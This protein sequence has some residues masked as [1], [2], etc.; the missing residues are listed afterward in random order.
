MFQIYACLTVDQS[1]DPDHGLGIK[2][3]PLEL[4]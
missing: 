3:H 1:I 2:Q 4:S